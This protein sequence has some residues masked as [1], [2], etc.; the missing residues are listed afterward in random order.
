DPADTAWPIVTIVPWSGE[1]EEA[2]A[3][4][5]EEALGI[6]V[7]VEIKPFGEYSTRLEQDPPQMWALSWIADYPH[8][9]DFLGLLL[10][11]GS[12]SNTGHWSNA[13]YDA[14]LGQAAAT[15]DVAE[16]TQL[17]GQAQDILAR[18]A[19]VV[20]VAYDRSFALSRS[21]LLGALESGL[22]FIRY[23]GMAWS[24]G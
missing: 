4:Q 1:F 24:P 12:V 3:K 2:V 19:P 14:L 5:L 23:A 15:A 22:D 7:S 18:E 16:Q 13:E 11:T 6:D 17:Y 8:P 21:G 10:E 20:P 9:Q